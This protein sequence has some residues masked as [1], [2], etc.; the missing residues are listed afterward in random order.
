M[1]KNKPFLQVLIGVILVLI[2]GGY[3]FYNFKTSEKDYSAQILERQNKILAEKSSKE[4]REKKA[5]QKIIVA[6]IQEKNTKISQVQAE[7][8]AET[9]IKVSKENG[10]SPYI[11]TALLASESSFIANPKHD[12]SNVIGMGGIYWSVWHKELKE[13]GIAYS[14]DELRNPYKN[15]MASSMIFSTYMKESKTP[16]EAL[17]RYKGYC[18]LGKKQ[19]NAVM[20]VAL[21]LKQRALKEQNV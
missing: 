2:S 1:V 16:R 13:E 17:A 8:Y 11:Q 14:K 20:T 21:N 4:Y 3:G 7:K 6:Y 18:S 15:I 5:T 12:I 10:T 19:A 9:I